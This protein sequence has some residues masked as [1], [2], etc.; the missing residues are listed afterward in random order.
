MSTWVYFLSDCKYVN[1]VW[2]EFVHN[3]LINDVIYAVVQFFKYRKK[4]TWLKFKEIANLF[5]P[6]FFFWHFWKILS[7]A[8]EYLIWEFINSQPFIL[9]ILSSDNLSWGK[10]F[11]YR[12]NVDLFHCMVCFCFILQVTLAHPIHSLLHH[13]HHDDKTRSTHQLQRKIYWHLEGKLLVP[14]NPQR[15]V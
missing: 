8:C 4:K 11:V 9:Y 10:C 3:Q 13:I 14:S 6:S 12:R 7:I 1:S 15:F 5:F 2:N